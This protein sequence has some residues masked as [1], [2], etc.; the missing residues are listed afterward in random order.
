MST[1]EFVHRVLADPDCE[2]FSTACSAPEPGFR[3]IGPVS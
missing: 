1:S 2:P 3:T